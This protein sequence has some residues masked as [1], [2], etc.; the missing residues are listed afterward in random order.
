MEQLSFYTENRNHD[1]GALYDSASETAMALLQMLY[2][3]AELDAEFLEFQL[4]GS[5]AN[6]RSN[7]L[8]KKVNVLLGSKMFFFFF[9]NN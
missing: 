3:E 2:T 8:E 9:F 1:Q 7:V 6:I 4:K 5:V